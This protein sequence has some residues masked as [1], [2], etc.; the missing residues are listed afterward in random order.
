M[1]T[2]CSVGR[3]N[4][5]ILGPSC[6]AVSS[7]IV[8]TGRTGKQRGRVPT[9]MCTPSLPTSK[10]ACSC[11]DGPGA[12][13]RRPSPP[14]SLPRRVGKAAQSGLSPEV[15]TAAKCFSDQRK[16]WASFTVLYCKHPLT[17]PWCSRGRCA[18][19]YTSVVPPYCSS[20]TG[21]P[22]GG[23]SKRGGET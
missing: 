11:G 23:V 16:R 4:R 21:K 5:S 19:N 12:P 8:I 9:D 6:L 22:V 1:R 13:A 3:C 7:R 10:V 15:P 14:G 18:Q 17:G 20:G 2:L